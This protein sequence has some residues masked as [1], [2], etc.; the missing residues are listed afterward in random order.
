MENLSESEIE[1]FI[2][3]MGNNTIPNCDSNKEWII[4]FEKADSLKK[5]VHYTK[6][7]K[8]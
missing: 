7:V 8:K 4:D 2:T 3:G 5:Y 1:S 6:I